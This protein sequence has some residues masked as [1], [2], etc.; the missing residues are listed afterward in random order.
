MK[1]EGF[2]HLLL[3]QRAQIIIVTNH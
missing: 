3:I 1:I 2:T